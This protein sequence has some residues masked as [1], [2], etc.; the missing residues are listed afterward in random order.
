MLPDSVVAVEKQETEIGAL[1]GALSAV[2]R[3]VRDYR[4]KLAE[5]WKQP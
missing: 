5:R 3:Q 4:E 2:E 1:K